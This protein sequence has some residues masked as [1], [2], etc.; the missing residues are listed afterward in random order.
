MMLMPELTQEAFEVCMRSGAWFSVG[1]VDTYY[2]GDDFNGTGNLPPAVSRVYVDNE[3]D[4]ISFDGSEF[5]NV[6]WISNGKIIAEGKGLTSIDLNEYEDVLGS[7][8]RFQITGPGGI[9]YSQPF[10]TMAEGVEYTSDVY[11]TFDISM[12]FRAFVDFYNATFGHGI[13]NTIIKKLLWNHI[14]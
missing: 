6:Q 12:F 14:W 4:T 5:N 2:L 8:V 10:V 3:T 13:I 1:R 9:L 7:Y 11:K